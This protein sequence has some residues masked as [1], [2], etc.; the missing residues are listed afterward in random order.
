M[1]ERLGGLTLLAVC[2]ASLCIMSPALAN[3]PKFP[4]QQSFAHV[5]GIDVEVLAY[6][7]M[8]DVSLT[9][10][11][12]KAYVLKQLVKAGLLGDHRSPSLQET[13]SSKNVKKGKP[14]SLVIL[15]I[16]VRRTE[17]S[18]MFVAKIGSVAVALQLFQQ[19]TIT[20]NQHPTQAI[21]W[22]ESESILGGSKRPKKIFEALDRLLEKFAHD[23]RI[24]RS[25]P[26]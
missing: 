12:M 23:F 8:D 1:K 6:E 13:R 4:D 5:S 20:H 22:S 16:R 24:D 11:A 2:A 21:T 3:P 9:A 25:T 7:N 15:G 14:E 19:V 17:D 10:E 18:A 26:Q